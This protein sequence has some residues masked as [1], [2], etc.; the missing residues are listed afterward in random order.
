MPG[1]W[2]V[3]DVLQVDRAFVA[4]VTLERLSHYLQGLAVPEVVPD[5]LGHAKV[6]P[7]DLLLP[8]QGCRLGR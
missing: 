6:I 7:G 4:R 1:F 8:G 3:G 5:E 2:G